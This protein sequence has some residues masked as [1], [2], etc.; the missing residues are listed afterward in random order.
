MLTRYKGGTKG[1]LIACHGLGTNSRIFKLTTVQRNF[2]E[3]FVSNE[4]DVWLLDSRQ[5]TFCP[6]ASESD[7]YALDDLAKFDFPAAVDLVLKHTK[8]V[9]YLAITENFGAQKHEKIHI[10]LSF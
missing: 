7:K 9:S 5:S 10:R 3:Y 1:P 2:V 4:Y 8:R 6:W